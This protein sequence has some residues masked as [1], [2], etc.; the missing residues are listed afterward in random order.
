[1]K[2][3][4]YNKQVKKEK[5]NS[6]IGRLKQIKDKIVNFISVKIKSIKDYIQKQIKNNEIIKKIFYKNKNKEK[7]KK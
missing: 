5:E 4:A 3:K 7:P 2:E 6:I 1:M